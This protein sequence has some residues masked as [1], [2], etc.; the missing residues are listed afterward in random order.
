MTATRQAVTHIRE[1]RWFEL[2][3]ILQGKPDTH[4]TYAFRA[5][6]RKPLV[7]SYMQSP[8]VVTFRKSLTKLNWSTA[9]EK[10][11]SWPNPHHID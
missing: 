8:Y 3:Y 7:A 9:P 11:G 6:P 5:N 2:M 10:N 1:S 4:D